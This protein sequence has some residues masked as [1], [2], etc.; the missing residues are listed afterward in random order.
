MRCIRKKGI[1]GAGKVF[2]A[3]KSLDGGIM[4]L[5]ARFSY[6]KTTKQ[7]GVQ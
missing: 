1:H 5:K 6:E 2:C 4:G 7:G 3:R